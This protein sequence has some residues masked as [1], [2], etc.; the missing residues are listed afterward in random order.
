[1]FTA[2]RMTYYLK[3][4]SPNVTLEDIA[5]LGKGVRWVS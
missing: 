5:I 2:P 3:R 4:V 1:M